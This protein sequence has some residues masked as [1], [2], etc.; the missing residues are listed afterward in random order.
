MCL[1]FIDLSAAEVIDL[2]VAAG[3]AALAIGT[4]SMARAT[5]KMA[6]ASEIQAELSR[7]QLEIATT[8]SLRV[9]RI[10]QPSQADMVTVNESSDSE[11]LVLHLENRGTMPAEV[12]YIALL[13]GGE[14][15]IVDHDE[16]ST[17]AIERGQDR[18][19]EFFPARWCFGRSSMAFP[20]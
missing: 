4:F 19:F 11:A 7:S 9:V 2:V 20:R 3:T 17:P 12:G 13:P 15:R 16:M 18:E 10:G 5:K 6:V 14:G 1:A 8:P